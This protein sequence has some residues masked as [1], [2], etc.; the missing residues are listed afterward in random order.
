[1]YYGV[2][3]GGTKVEIGIFDQDFTLLDRWRVATP[4]GDY[5]SFLCC[6]SDLIFKADKKS[7]VTGLVGL[8]MAGLIDK[9]NISLSANIPSAS[10]HDIVADLSAKIDRL[11]TCENDSRCFALSEATGGAAAGFCNVYGAIIGT[12]AAGGLLIDGKL[13]SSRQGL[14]GE[15][16]H[17]ALS[18]FLQQ[19]YDLP[20]RTCGCG[21]TSCY[22]CYISGPGLVFLGSHFGGG[23]DSVPQ[24][25]LAYRQGDESAKAA[26]SCYLDILGASFANLV[27]AYDPD[28]IV[29][30][31][32]IS[33]IDEVVEQLPTHMEDYIFKGFNAPPVV[34]AKFGDA[35]GVRGAALIAKGATND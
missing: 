33:L 9:N 26:F 2:D 27:L 24:L 5:Q 17:F 16:G 15:Y 22:E 14:A 11:V 3:I 8:G 32:G 13:I 28:V 35:S 6:L 7:G 19:K 25:I 20:L 29:L 18:A 21:L 12:G 1:M 30:G 23:F 31:G 10:G 4:D 34:R